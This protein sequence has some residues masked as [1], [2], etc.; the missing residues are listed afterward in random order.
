MPRF[1]SHINRPAR[2]FIRSDDAI[3]RAGSGNPGDFIMPL[4]EPIMEAKGVQLL[5]ARIPNIFPQVPDYQRWFIYM[6]TD[7]Q[8][9]KH[10]RGFRLCATTER[11]R[12]FVN[13]QDM[14]DQLNDDC[15]YWVEF[16]MRTLTSGRHYLALGL[17]PST[18]D[19][20]FEYNA[21]T[22][23]IICKNV[24]LA[25]PSNSYQLINGVNN[26]LQFTQTYGGTT[27]YT[28]VTVPAGMYANTAALAVA[29]TNAIADTG[30]LGISVS[31]P[32]DGQLQYTWTVTAAQNSLVFNDI[33]LHIQPASP[34]I[35][36]LRL[37]SHILIPTTKCQA[38]P[39]I[40]I[41][42]YRLPYHQ[43]LQRYSLP[44]WR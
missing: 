28:F 15:K 12:Y 19:V 41:S 4:L 43:H 20:A 8:G 33:R 35:L 24:A 21:L 2:V 14:V 9:F 23:K 27:D 42:R 25:P 26:V 7:Y 39:S 44:T 40:T 16:N 34:K 10:I 30:G 13:Y 32:V 22:R 29:M 6:L 31:S 5:G 1:L 18:P 38:I 36:H 37:V 11:Q 17:V 3:D